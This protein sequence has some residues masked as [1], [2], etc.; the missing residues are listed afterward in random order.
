MISRYAIITKAR[1]FVNVPWV[2]QGRSKET[3]IDCVGLIALT[4]QA[5]DLT[6][7]DL[8][9]YSQQPDGITLHRELDKWFIQKE[10]SDIIPGNILTFWVEHRS[11]PCH[12][13]IITNDYRGSLGLVH[14]WRNK[15]RCV[16]HRF[17][18]G[19]V[20]WRRIARVYEFP[21]VEPWQQ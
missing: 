8:A 20:W 18:E 1:S 2:H 11:R 10:L 16:E 21:G 7:H 13:G 6:Y 19:S 3:G 12:A 14:T 15:G 4:A 17:V 9:V 5:F